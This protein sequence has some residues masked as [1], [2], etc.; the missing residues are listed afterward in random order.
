MNASQV[1]RSQ[2]GSASARATR[3]AAS[4]ARLAR[5]GCSAAIAAAFG[6][7]RSEARRLIDQGG[8]RIADDVVDG[9]R[10]D[11]PARDLDGALLQI[12]RRR[13]RRLRVA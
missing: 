7:S 4:L 10:L 12:G 1:T 13:F 5:A 6:I 11:L 9:Q 3:S 2:R 8:V